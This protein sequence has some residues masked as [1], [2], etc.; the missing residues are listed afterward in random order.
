MTVKREKVIA[1]DTSVPVVVLYTYHYG[2]LGVLRSFGRLGIAVHGVDPNPRS[3][4]LFSRYCQ[5]KFLFDVD[6]APSRVSVQ[7]LLD[8]AKKIGKRSILIHTTDSGAGW[9]ADNAEA[10]SEGYIFPKL[11]SQLVLALANKKEMY[12]LAKK[13]GVPTPEACFPLSL[14]DVEEY[15]KDAVFPVVLKELYRGGSP[16]VGKRMFVAKTKAELLKFYSQCEDSLNPN[17]MLQEYIPGGDDSIWMFNG[18]FNEKSDCLF[19]MTGRK[20]RQSPIHTGVTSLGVCLKNPLVDEMTRGF[21]K[22][23]GYKGILDIGYRY[24]MRDGKYKVLDINPRIGS[25]FRL[26]VGDNGLDVARAQYLDLTGQSVPSSELVEGRKWFVEDRDSVSSFRYH[27]EKSLTFKQW[28][29]SFRG[30]QESAWFAW[31]DLSPFFMM[32]A[33]SSRKVLSKTDN[34]ALNPYKL[35]P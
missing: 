28:L 33:R 20:I 21:M 9:L 32:C 29:A 5:K 24:D 23:I 8:V 27:Y 12:F 16:R 2:Q 25:T 3:P 17:F 11:S 15:V 6:A 7:Y 19:G 13:C 34:N 10:L 18:Y 26:F 30:V 22:S 31:D 1:E 35:T 14:G 4:G